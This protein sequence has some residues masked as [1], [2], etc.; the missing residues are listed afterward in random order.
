MVA[1]LVIEQTA[2][3]LA[4]KATPA[5]LITCFGD[6]LQIRKK[7]YLLRYSLESRTF[8]ERRAL[9]FWKTISSVGSIAA[10]PPSSV[11]IDLTR[12]RT[13]AL[14]RYGARARLLG[15]REESRRGSYASDE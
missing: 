12:E 8:A 1:S 4:M 9:F 2:P 11:R 5:L 3:L 15:M 6:A 7:D 13:Q 14:P 10:I